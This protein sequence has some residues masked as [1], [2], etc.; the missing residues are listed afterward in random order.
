MGFFNFPH[1]TSTNQGKRL[2][3]YQIARILN[4]EGWPTRKATEWRGSQVSS[5]LKHLSSRT[6]RKRTQ[7]S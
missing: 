1:I 3:P 4:K 2:G 5:I 6:R 7:S